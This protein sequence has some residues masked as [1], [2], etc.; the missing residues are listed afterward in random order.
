MKPKTQCLIDG[1]KLDYH[2][3]SR[4]DRETADALANRMDMDYIGSGYTMY[5]NGIE[6]IFDDLHHFYAK[7]ASAKSDKFEYLLH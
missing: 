5:I 3:C 1:Q 2:F 6:N 4:N 7:K